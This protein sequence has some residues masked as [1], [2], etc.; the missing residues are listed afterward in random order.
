MGIPLLVETPLWPFGKRNESPGFWPSGTTPHGRYLI[1]FCGSHTVVIHHLPCLGC[2]QKLYRFNTPF[3][4]DDLSNLILILLVTI[5]MLLVCLSRFYTKYSIYW[6]NPLS[7]SDSL[8][9]IP[10]LSCTK[11]TTT[12]KKT[13]LQPGETPLKQKI[14]WLCRYPLVNQHSY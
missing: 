14:H 12:C 7:F 6:W 13:P 11:N 10:F 5:V 2:P 1:N 4:L 3:Q 9:E 8:A